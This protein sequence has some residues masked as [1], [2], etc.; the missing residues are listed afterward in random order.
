VCFGFYWCVAFCG[1][2]FFL[3]VVVVVLLFSS[4]LLGGVWGCFGGHIVCR[5]VGS[6]FL[7]VRPLPK[8]VHRGA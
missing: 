4:E 5:P 3:V 1:C 6:N 2:F 8:A 7:V